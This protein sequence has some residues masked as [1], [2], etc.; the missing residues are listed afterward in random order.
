MPIATLIKLVILS[1]ASAPFSFPP[2]LLRRADA[3]SK[4]LLVPGLA[5]FETRV[6]KYPSTLGEPSDPE[7]SVSVHSMNRCSPEYLPGLEPRET[8]G[9]HILD[10]SPVKKR[11][12][13]PQ[14]RGH[15]PHTR[16]FFEPRPGCTR[17]AR[18]IVISST[19]IVMFGVF[20]NTFC[21]FSTYFLEKAGSSPDLYLS[22]MA[23]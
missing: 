19:L 21:H 3:Q 22:R 14:T 10:G 23:V 12:R 20:M 7:A 17:P 15:P 8:W 4:D 18:Q 6:R 11:E 9:T 5:T 13:R 2:R 16:K 1:G